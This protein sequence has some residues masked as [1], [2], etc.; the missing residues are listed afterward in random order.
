LLNWNFIDAC[1]IFRKTAWERCGGYD[2]KMPSQGFEDWDFWCRVAL[3][4]GAFYHVAEILFDYRIREDSMSSTMG[5]PERMNKI[6]QHMRQKRIEI[7]VGNY[8]DALQSWESV[9]TELRSRPLKTFAAI[10]GLTYFPKIYTKWRVRTR[11][12]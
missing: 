4:G 5:T 12:P 3:N 2:E 1:A 11:K 7:S 10:I 8:I 9:V 6:I